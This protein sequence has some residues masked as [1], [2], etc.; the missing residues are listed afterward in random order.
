MKVRLPEEIRGE[1]GFAYDKVFIPKGEAKNLC[2]KASS[3]KALISHRVQGLKDLL[4]AFRAW[5]DFRRSSLFFS[6]LN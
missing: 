6:K 4:S 5:K 1:G 2:G 3:L